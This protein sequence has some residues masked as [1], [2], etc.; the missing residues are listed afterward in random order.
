MN[1]ALYLLIVFIFSNLTWQIIIWGNDLVH[2][3]LGIALVLV[4]PI[5]AGVAVYLI[6]LDKIDDDWSTIFLAS[7]VLFPIFY[8]SLYATR[9][10]EYVR[11]VH[12][13]YHR[14]AGAVGE[15]NSSEPLFYELSDF[16]VKDAKSG[17][18]GV[19]YSSSSRKSSTTHAKHF[20]VPLFDK[21]NAIA[22][23]RLWLVDT[24]KTGSSRADSGDHG[25]YGFEK[26]RLG[27][28]ALNAST[29]YAKRANSYDAQRAVQQYLKK[30]NLPPDENPLILELVDEP[31][32]EYY[33]KG[34]IY[35]LIWTFFF[36]LFYLGASAYVSRKR[37]DS[38]KI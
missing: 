15:I 11:F 35:L 21:N 27:G 8:W 18:F 20:V 29:L 25:I 1:R 32:Q 10:P 34:K 38:G 17:A 6:F 37:S 22:A 14:F 26:T 9:A 16:H 13:G 2:P 24:Y 7:G 28:G 30:M 4:F 19:S 23:P 5:F 12:S 33:R 36:N 3:L 31:A